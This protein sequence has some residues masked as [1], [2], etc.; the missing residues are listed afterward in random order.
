V[1]SF[2]RSTLEEYLA[3]LQPG[4]KL[5][6]FV[7]LL[8]D[9]ALMRVWHVVQDNLSNYAYPVI[10]HELPQTGAAPGLHKGDP[11]ALHRLGA[12]WGFR[13]LLGA[14]YLQF[15]WLITSR[16]DIKRCK[17]C[18]H[19]IPSQRRPGKERRS[20]ASVAAILNTATSHASRT[21]LITILRNRN[22]GVRAPS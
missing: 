2:A 6:D 11:F 21:T 9:K 19:I 18:G 14:A 3:N 7:D 12:A 4:S 16:A 1:K 5:P 15:Y 8:V 22:A 13:N 10:N 17:Y 20:H